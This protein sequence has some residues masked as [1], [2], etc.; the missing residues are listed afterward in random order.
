M[1]VPISKV[2]FGHGDLAVQTVSKLG[3]RA[4]TG[5]KAAEKLVTVFD[6]GGNDE[7]R[8]LEVVRHGHTTGATRDANMTA[9]LLLLLGWH[10]RSG[11][12]RFGPRNDENVLPRDSN[13]I[14]I[15]L[16]SIDGQADIAIGRVGTITGTP[17]AGSHCILLLPTLLLSFKT[18]HHL[19]P[20]LQM[21]TILLP[22]SKLSLLLIL[23]LHLYFLLLL[24]L[25]FKTIHNL[26]VL[27]RSIP[28][29]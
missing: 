4:A 3:T 26:L 29:Q 13:V 18:L 14:I 24:F 22:H 16:R 7:V 5:R 6:R 19:N 12:G 11:G 8:R 25:P 15:P 27:K 1:L 10:G 9:L 17:L 20:L 2:A 21:P 28:K 23:P